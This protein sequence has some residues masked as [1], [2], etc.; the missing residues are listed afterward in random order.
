MQ[1][2]ILWF[3]LTLL[4]IPT[5]NSQDA[6]R[7]VDSLKKDVNIQSIDL[8]SKIAYADVKNSF[9]VVQ[10]ESGRLHVFDSTGAN[11]LSLTTDL[12]PY[13]RSEVLSGMNRLLIVKNR[14]MNKFYLDWNSIMRRLKTIFGVKSTLE[15]RYLENG[16][17]ITEYS[18]NGHVLAT[19]TDRHN[20]Y[21]G[22]L[23]YYNGLIRIEIL[24]VKTGKINF[25]NEVSRHVSQFFFD[26]DSVYAIT[27]NSITS[28]KMDILS[29]TAT[30]S[31]KNYGTTFFQFQT[32]QKKGA[33]PKIICYNG[34]VDSTIGPIRLKSAKELVTKFK[35]F[36][37]NHVDKEIEFQQLHSSEIVIARAENYFAIVDFETS[38]FN[39]YDISNCP[40]IVYKSKLFKLSS[41]KWMAVPY[42]GT[43]KEQKLVL[44]VD[45]ESCWQ[46]TK[47]NLMDVE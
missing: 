27:S 31:Y 8:Y 23:I 5:L 40:E 26:S 38:E 19:Q 9:A 41:G 35:D 42:L 14:Y 30:E 13:V 28:Y 17:I 18:F 24:N 39:T 36:R 45:L 11:I 34:S 29:N 16:E 7:N 2:I 22:L 6:N 12:D 37:M 43:E 32:F 20:K 46:E 44:F 33:D 15:I 10:L 3:C 4:L 1:R 47:E 25:K 21:L